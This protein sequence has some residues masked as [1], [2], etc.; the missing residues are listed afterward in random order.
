MSALASSGSGLQAKLLWA[1]VA[2]VGAVCFGV[3][4]LTGEESVNAGGW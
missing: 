4:A 1:A 2:A 3:V